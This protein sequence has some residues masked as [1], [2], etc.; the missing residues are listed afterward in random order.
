MRFIETP[1]AARLYEAVRTLPIVDYH[2]HLSPKEIWE[3]QPFDNIGEMWLA[4]DHYKWRLMREYGIDEQYVTGNADWYDKF[5]KYIEALEYAA[6]N[7]L[8]HW[9][10]MELEQYFDVQEA[11][12]LANATLIWEKANAKIKREK[13]SPRKLIT[14]SNVTFIATTDDPAD[15]LKYH[16]LIREDASFPVQVT[17]SF[18]T[19]RLLQIAAA[20]YPAYIAGLEQAAEM[21]ITDLSSFKKAIEKRL[22]FFVSLGCRMTDVGLPVFPDRIGSEEEADAALQKALSGKKTEPAECLAFLGDMYVFLGAAYRE[23]GLVMQWHLAVSRNAN[24][25]IFT[26]YGPDAGCD[27]MGASIP[28]AHIIRVL[29]A[30]DQTGGLPKTLLYTLVP[31]M[32]APLSTVAGSFRN[33]SLGAAWWFCDH[34]RGILEQLDVIAETGHLGIFPG[35]LTDSRSF[36][37]YARHDYYR[38]LVCQWIANLAE[39]DEFDPSAAERLAVKL[40]YENAQRL[41]EDNA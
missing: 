9:S 31:S 6:G 13:L 16:R 7:P 39:R 34:K 23:R 14:Q 15:S 10:K 25:R 17:P 18:R 41:T 22:D 29:D 36:L 27:C 30:I 40:C 32:A 37:S 8:Y 21:K 20:D 12:T 5:L 3:D 2:C 11:L 28:M 19:D 33:V 1:S 4:G 26:Q 38:R 24:T 35:M